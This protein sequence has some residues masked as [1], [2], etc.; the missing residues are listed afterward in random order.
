VSS[1]RKTGSRRYRYAVEKGRDPYA[2]SVRKD[3]LHEVILEITCNGRDGDPD[4][5]EQVILC[6][7]R[8]LDDWAKGIYLYS[9]RN[10]QPPT[11]LIDSRR[12]RELKGLFGGESR[13]GEDG[14]LY[15]T[16]YL[17]NTSP[18][19]PKCPAMPRITAEKL[20][21]WIDALLKWSGG[22]PIKKRVDFRKLP[23]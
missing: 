9:A 19:C 3:Q 12:A 7:A 15:T 16:E 2:V 4:H 11:P 22:K 18:K 10:I 23:T 13:E 5:G 21:L 17:A 20:E 14:F 1:G 6:A 8:D